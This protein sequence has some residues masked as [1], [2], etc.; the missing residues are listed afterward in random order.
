MNILLP[1]ET[2]NREIDFKL[3]LAGYLAGKGHQIYIGQHD[4]LMNLVPNLKK[5]GLYIGKNI[6]TK[7]SPNDRGEK[8]FFLKKH[9][10]NIIYLHEEGAI[11]NIRKNFAETLKMQYN[12]NFFDQNDCVC[13]W[14]QFQKKIE[15]LRTKKVPIYV[16]GHPRFDLYKKDW[17]K[18]HKSQISKLKKKYKNFVLINGNYS[19][20]NHGMGLR[21][22]FRNNLATKQ[23][24]IK[25]LNIYLSSKKQ[26][27]SMVELTVHLAL[28][29]PKT[30][31]I[32]RPHPSE[33]HEYYH[34]I[35][36]GINNII[37][38]HEGP[39]SPW[40]LASKLLIHDG[41]TTAIEANLANIPVINY[42]PY[43]YSNYDLW[44]PNQ[45]GIQIKTTDKIISYIKSMNKKKNKQSLR[46]KNKQIFNYIHNF[47]NNSFKEFLNII[48]QKINPNQSNNRIS[49]LLIKIYYLKSYIKESLYKILKF[50]KKQEIKYH[51]TKFYGFNQNYIIE[52]YKIISNI[53]NK[54]ISFKFHNSNLI[55][56][57]DKEDHH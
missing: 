5:G 12:I 19:A 44:L 51:K 32:Y 54:K 13:V 3:V 4:F 38:N 57:D 34:I 1:I 18:F 8:Y 45:I 35:F 33:D 7:S 53:L 49:S 31:F 23:D 25:L 55:S 26:L 36:K 30:N 43:Y 6:F 11:F 24:K 15:R 22:F 27:H 56:I 40:I 37:V 28:K 52:K 48:E 29:F 41:C 20:S 17:K 21:Y 39:V 42:K 46:V 10:F 50:N 9:N 2:I 47:K 14:G 16:T